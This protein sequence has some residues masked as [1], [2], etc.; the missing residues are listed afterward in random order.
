MIGAIRLE[1]G[2]LSH[3][4]L[5]ESHDKHFDVNYCTFGEPPVDAIS[6]H[7]QAKNAVGLS[8]AIGA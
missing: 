2:F 4:A 7:A 3:P 5:L 6:E 8:A 1:S